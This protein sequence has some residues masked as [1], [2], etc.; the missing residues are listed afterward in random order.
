VKKYSGSLALALED[1]GFDAPLAEF[2]T[3]LSPSALEFFG[4]VVNNL[5]LFFGSELEGFVGVLLDELLVLPELLIPLLG[6]FFSS[7]EAELSFPL[8]E[9]FAVLSSFVEL[10]PAL[11]GSL[12]VADAS[13][14]SLVLVLSFP[15]PLELELVKSSYFSLGVNL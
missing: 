10:A 1:V 14:E 11:A 15:S 5:L 9:A 2:P 12:L 13:L 7:L 8:S 4:V 6:V 3:V